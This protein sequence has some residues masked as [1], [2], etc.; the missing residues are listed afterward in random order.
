MKAERRVAGGLNLIAA[1]TWSKALSTQDA[2]TVGGGWYTGNVQD[3]LNLSGEKSP[4]AFDLRHR[5][6]TAVIYNIPFFGNAKS[7]AVKAMLGGW[8]VSTI[9]TEQTGFGLTMAGVGD[10]T[11]TGISSRVSM[12]SGQRAELSRGER[13]RSRWFN[14]AAFAVTPMGQWGNAT[15]NPLHLPGYNNIDLAANKYFRFSESANVQFRAE[16]FN[17]V[18]H[19]NLGA[20]GTSILAPNT[21]GI[22]TSGS[23]GP[24]ATGDQRIIQLGLKF[25]F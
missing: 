17:F 5:F 12:V 24:G 10:T 9:V 21:F 11:G 20:P 18:N 6:S 14:T 7:R 4:A 19:V 16:M 15:R 13:S 8:Q 3:I 2:S 22:I 23:Q 1:Y 25:Q